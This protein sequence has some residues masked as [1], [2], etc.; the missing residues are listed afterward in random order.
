MK[1]LMCVVIFMLGFSLFFSNISLAE[2]E[3]VLQSQL[4]KRVDELIKIVKFGQVSSDYEPNK[5]DAVIGLG[6]LKDPQCVDILI[7]YLE[8]SDTAHFRH[9][10]IKSL[11]WIG[12]KRALPILINVLKNDDYTHARS[13]AA[14]ALGD[15]GGGEEVIAALEEAYNSDED[16]YVRNHV[17]ESLEKIT[18]KSYENQTDEIMREI[19]KDI[20][21]DVEK[22]LDK[23]KETSN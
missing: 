13:A 15:M 4:E 11:G 3:L 23:T 17:A 8:Y 12:D 7:E 21:K 2:S 14:S 9:Q 1:K 19:K 5:I 16:M 18:G 10:I 20:N 6:L 22:Y